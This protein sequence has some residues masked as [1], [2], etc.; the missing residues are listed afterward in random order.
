MVIARDRADLGAL[1][2]DP[3]WKPPVV[4]ADTPLWTDDFSNIFSVF[5][6]S[7]PRITQGKASE[8]AKSK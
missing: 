1:A 2:S 4:A 5:V 7:I 3:R 6:W 8:K